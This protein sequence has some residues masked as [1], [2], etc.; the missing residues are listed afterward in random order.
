MS[1][2][3]SRIP[4]PN[5]LIWFT[6]TESST[7]GVIAP[8]AADSGSDDAYSEA[9]A[10]NWRSR[11]NSAVDLLN[12]SKRVSKTHASTEQAH[13]NKSNVC[14]PSISGRV[15]GRCC[16][17]FAV[18]RVPEALLHPVAFVFLVGFPCR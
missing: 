13:A 10:P 8:G 17:L 18:R 2:L 1:H 7:I 6:N 3:R 12:A 16:S 14:K 15:C 9:C 5:W 11:K 4:G